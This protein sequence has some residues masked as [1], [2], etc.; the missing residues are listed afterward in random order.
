MDKRYDHQKW[1]SE[2]SSLWEENGAFS[3]KIDKNKKPA[4]VKERME[5][6]LEKI[7]VK[8]LRLI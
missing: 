1:E 4:M 2:I 3:A 7:R 6:S 8:S 5:N